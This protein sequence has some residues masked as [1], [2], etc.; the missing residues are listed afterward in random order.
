MAAKRRALV[1]AAVAAC[2]GPQIKNHDVDLSKVT[3]ATLEAERP[4]EGDPHPLTLRVYV[5]PG[6]KAL[7]KWKEEIT[8]QVDYAS[9]VLTPLIGVR[10]SIAETKD[11]ARSGDPGTALQ[12][13]E[14]LDKGDGVNWVVGYIAAN[15]SASK[16]FSELGGARPLG[17]HIIVHAWAEEQETAAIAGTLPDLKEAE[18]AQVMESHKR[19][20]QTVIL[21]HFLATTLGAIAETDPAWIGNVLY[22][23][24]QHGFAEKTR[25]LMTIAGDGRA[26]ELDNAEIAKRLLEV[27]DKE[28][29]GGW[30]AASKEE[31]TAYL[32]TLTDAANKGKVATDVPAAALDQLT[33]IKQLVKQDQVPTALAELDNLLAAYPATGT[34]H[35][36]KCDIMLAKVGVGDPKTMQACRRVTELAPGDPGP[37]I[38]IAEA[39][40]KG[41]KD[42]DIVAARKELQLAESKIV[43]LPDPAAA[44][45]TWRRVI[46]I[47]QGLGA[48]TWT[49]DAIV[50]AKLDKDPIAVSVAS[51]RARYGVPRGSKL[52]APEQEAALVA[53]VKKSLEL[54][55]G[56]KYGDA[57][58]ALAA[59][60]KKWPGAP[61]L[62][63]ARCDLA[64]RQGSVDAA[65]AN[66]NKALAADPNESWA[67]YL[68]GVIALKNASGT[69]EGIAQLK[70]AIAVDPDLGQAWRTLAKAYSRTKDKA[71]FEAL[72]AEYQ[73]RFNSQLQP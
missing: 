63:A 8:E 73:A 15:G 45:A 24:T 1:L 18:R 38:A 33:R 49:D 59:A 55:Y 60:E 44:E 4:R 48:L 34:L 61:G 29:W 10:L 22:S 19:H 65:K 39:Q 26:A 51:V 68:S 37:H 2:G 66:C 21:L 6:V 70:K 12:Q 35:Q 11:W 72:A 14:E 32:R 23:P 41:G 9:Q 20:K 62:Y 53:A 56:S 30:I 69:N 52:V 16:A 43:N 27:I 67:L 46:G 40:L 3:P 25:E 58:K 42:E 64:M 28:D 50:K 57:E 17:K 54:V 47:Y 31:T 13:L 71:A 36:L 5:D 7:P